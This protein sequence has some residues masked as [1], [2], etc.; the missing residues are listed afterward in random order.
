MLVHMVGDDGLGKWEE[1]EEGREHTNDNNAP[2]GIFNQLL[3]LFC[4][5]VSFRFP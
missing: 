1:E 3:H 4:I 5:P 2:L